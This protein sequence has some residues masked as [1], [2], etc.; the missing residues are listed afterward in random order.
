MQSSQHDLIVVG[1]G[2]AGAAAALRAAQYGLSLAWVLGDKESSRASR[3]RYVHEIDNMIG[4]H[5]GVLTS[6][7]AK[8]LRAEPEALEKISAAEL[9]IGTQDLIDNVVQ[10]IEEDFLDTTE[11]VHERAVHARQ[12]QERFVVELGEGG[13]VEGGSLVLATGV[14]DLQ[15]P[16]KKTLPS[17][18]LVDDI[19]WVFPWANWG[20]LLYCI[21]CEGHMTRGT[22]VAVIGSSE[23]TAQ[24]AMMLHE[25]YG[26]GVV[27][28]T[29]DRPLEAG[30]RSQALLEAY[31]IEIL[32]ERIVD[33]YDLEPDAEPP[34]KKPRK[35]TELHGLVLESGERVPARYA[36]VAMGL[37]RVYNELAEELGAEL[38]GGDLA[39]EQ[40][41][42]L[43]EDATAETSVRGLFAVG[44]MGRRRDGGPLMKQVYTAQEYAVRAVDTIDRRR[45]ARHRREV[46]GEPERV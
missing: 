28:L 6:K 42:V 32:R 31:G 18:K 13:Q 29:N 30:E 25:R 24:I 21:R 10:R 11:L 1:G 46:L 12:E 39:Q 35:G 14:M 3:G 36:M 37:H 27:I 43:I 19:R 34:A 2:V 44:D 41:H 22:Q 16:I 4:V 20:R 5:P 33:I 7:L 9:V 17:G 23:T 45:R 26:V 38:E 8:V 40:R 15:P